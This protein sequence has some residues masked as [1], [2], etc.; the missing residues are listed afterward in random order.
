[1]ETRAILCCCWAQYGKLTKQ[2]NRLLYTYFT[3]GELLLTDLANSDSVLLCSKFSA[4]CFD[5]L[6][7]SSN[8]LYL[9]VN[10]YT[11]GWIFIKMQIIFIQYQAYFLQQKVLQWLLLKRSITTCVMDM[12]PLIL[13][14]YLCLWT[15]F[16]APFLLDNSYRS[17]DSLSICTQLQE[18]LGWVNPGW[19]MH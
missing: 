13:V 14:E 17:W 3:R 2:I 5:S 7:I 9:C 1:M 11:M 15:I 18:I 6:N 10:M 4:A 16:V 12:N 8:T 19:S